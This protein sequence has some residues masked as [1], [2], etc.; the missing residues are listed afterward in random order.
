MLGP[1]QWQL[2]NFANKKNLSFSDRYKNKVNVVPFKKYLYQLRGC[3][4]PLRV[5]P[6]KNICFVLLARPCF[7]YSCVYYFCT[8]FV[9]HQKTGIGITLLECSFFKKI[10]EFIEIFLPASL[11]SSKGLLFTLLL[12]LLFLLLFL[13]LLLLLG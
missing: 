3:V 4:R 13:L 5:V 8:I 10:M 2:V 6:R 12:L 1:Q 7:C 11:K 9:I